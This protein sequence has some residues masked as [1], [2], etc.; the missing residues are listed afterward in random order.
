MDCKF[1]GLDDALLEQFIYGLLDLNLHRRILSR[2]ELSMKIAVDEDRAYKMAGQ[3]TPDL[4]RFPPSVMAL[5]LLRPSS[6]R[7]PTKSLSP[8]SMPPSTGCALFPSRTPG[9]VSAAVAATSVPPAVSE[10]RSAANAVAITGIN[11]LQLAS[12]ID[13]LV[14]EFADVFSEALG[15]YKGTPISLN[16]DPLVVP[17]RLKAHRVPLALRAKVDAELDKLISQGILEP[18]DHAPW[19]TPIVLPLKSDGSL[20]VCADYKATVN[21]AL[22]AHPYP[23]PVVQHVLHSLGQGKIFAK[24]DL[25]QAYQQLP[26]DD[27]T[28]TTTTIITHRG[29][30]R[31][32]CLQFGISV[33]P[34]LF[35]GLM[36]RLLY[37]I[38]G[39]T[40]Y[41]NDVLIAAPDQSGLIS[42]L[43]AVLSHFCAAGLHLKRSKCC[44]GSHS[45]T[46]NFLSFHV[47][48]QGIHPSP[49]K[50]EA[51]TNVPTPSSKAELQAFLGLLNFYATFIPH[52][53]SYG[54]RL[55]L[56]LACDVSPYGMGTVLSH[57]FPDGSEAPITYYSRTLSRAERNYSHLDKEALVSIAGVKRF[58]NYLYGRPFTLL[59]NHK[60]LFGILAGD[61]ATPRI[62]SPR[63]SRWSEFLSAYAYRLQYQPGKHMGHMDALSR[64]LLPLTL[65][66]PAPSIASGVFLINNL[67][68]PLSASDITTSTASDLLLSRVLDAVRRGWTADSQAPKFLLFLGRP[69]EL[70]VLQGCLLWGSRV[71]MP[72]ALRQ[73]VLRRLHEGHPGIVCMKALG[74]GYVWWPSMDADITGWVQRCPSCQAVHPVA[75]SSPPQEW[76]TPSSPWSRLQA[77]FFG[78]IDGRSFLLVVD[79]LS[80]WVEVIHLCSV[81]SA[82]TIH[83]LECLF[84]THGLPDTLVTDNGPQFSSTELRL[85]LASLGIRHAPVAP[86][87]PASN[88]MAECAVRSAKES[89][90]RLSPLPWPTCLCTYLRAQHSTPCAATGKSPAK[91]LM[92]RRLHI[93]LDRL[94]PHFSPLS[95]SLESTPRAFRVGEEVYAQNYL[96]EPKWVLAVVQELTGPC[97]YRV[98]LAD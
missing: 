62:L 90:A 29:A 25:A 68:L 38:P 1:L 96:S 32:T 98:Q 33:A 2:T 57:S 55:P 18:M 53:A 19:E 95:I 59:T 35:Q 31:C 60:P 91:V 86:Y 52:K 28:A 79:A 66:D 83:A 36:E 74:R 61:R 39:V 97:S 71:V 11:S 85:Y 15:C 4:H 63:M 69:T 9:P 5:F 8:T 22:Q 72:P 34:S 13:L 65:S 88:G 58:H 40:P 3:S 89:L 64:C 44:L 78:P 50:I 51:I 30:F 41:F 75:P 23:V 47:D 67:A 94:H 17:I 42:T 7:C 70:S 76:E 37:G 77:D 45:S 24:L 80:K 6:A 92:G 26:V 20:R 21:K 87:H 49:A 73:L 56:L 43:R 93:T 16:L 27:A 82:A 54:E 48:G 81:T 46:V 10:P 84:S 14:S 12:D